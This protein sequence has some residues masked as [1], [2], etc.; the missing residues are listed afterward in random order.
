M[1][2]VNN[3]IVSDEIPLAQFSCLL[4]QCLGACCVQGEEGA[5]LATDELHRL[6]AVLPVVQKYLRPEALEEIEQK[7]VWEEIAPNRYATTC[8]EG[9]ACVFVTYEGQVAHCAI[10]KAYYK[11]EVDW[12]KPI[13]CHLY[14]I[15][16]SNYG[17]H[18]VLNY[19]QI[20]ICAPARQCGC[21]HQVNLY[22]YLAEPLTR[23]YGAQWYQAFREACIQ[24]AA[25]LN[26]V[27]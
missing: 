1:F 23:K 14:P 7:G 9:E 22:E 25:E 16:I 18:E 17:G 15:R 3:V 21:D 24:R 11:G 19:E 13:S 8:V 20:G 6:E 12:I 10:Q 5:P 4:S 26:N 27:L 2:V